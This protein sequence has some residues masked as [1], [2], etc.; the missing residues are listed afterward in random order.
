M[1]FHLKTFA[2]VAEGIARIAYPPAGAIID[3]AKAI[4]D[5][6]GPD[7]SIDILAEIDSSLVAAGDLTGKS[8]L[9]DPAV[10]ALAQ[11]YAQDGLALHALIEAKKAAKLAAPAT[12]ADLGVPAGSTGE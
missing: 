4:H 1:K 12:G 7:R 11:K 8:V 2:H 3:G 9:A 5:D 10:R 6:H